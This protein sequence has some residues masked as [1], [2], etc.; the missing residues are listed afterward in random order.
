ME[1]IAKRLKVSAVTVSK[2]LKGDPDIS[3]ETSRKVKKLAHE[4]GYIPNLFF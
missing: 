1:D 4:L 2:A 3:E